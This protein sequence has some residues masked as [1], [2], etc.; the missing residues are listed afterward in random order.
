[1]EQYSNINKQQ[2]FGSTNVS[3]EWYIQNIINFIQ[4]AKAG[5]P[6]ELKN[7]I[8]DSVFFGRKK[9]LRFES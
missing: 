3:E 8:K 1:M 4:E 7:I 5:L 9:F 2:H 6:E